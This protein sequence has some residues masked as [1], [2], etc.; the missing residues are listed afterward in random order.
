MATLSKATLMFF[1]SAAILLDHKGEV[2]GYDTE[3]DIRKQVGKNYL[4]SWD[5][6]KG[7]LRKDCRPILTSED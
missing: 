1:L 6:A 4:Y 3:E 7:D 2:F 5:R